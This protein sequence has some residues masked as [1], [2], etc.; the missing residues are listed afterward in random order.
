MGQLAEAV[1]GPLLVQD[2]LVDQAVGIQGTG[3]SAQLVACMAAADAGDCLARLQPQGL[4][5]QQA[6]GFEQAATHE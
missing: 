1:L 2:P 4:F 3:Q 5:G 6:Q